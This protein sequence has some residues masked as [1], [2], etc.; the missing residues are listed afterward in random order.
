M[1]LKRL[2]TKI[3]KIMKVHELIDLINNSE[4]TLY[5]LWDAEELIP[6]EIKQVAQGLELDEHRW[7]STAVNVYECEDGYVGIFGAYQSFS[8]MQT[9]SDICV[10]C[11]AMEYKQVQTVTYIRK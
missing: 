2:K 3:S 9:W 6:R 1:P 8:E 5:S 10:S 4:E 7:Y 11:D